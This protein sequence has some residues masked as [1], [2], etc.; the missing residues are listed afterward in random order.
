MTGNWKLSG[1]WKLFLTIAQFAAFIVVD[2]GLLESL[3]WL[4]DAACPSGIAR[5]SRTGKSR[6]LDAARGRQLHPSTAGNLRQWS[7]RPDYFWDAPPEP[8]EDSECK[9]KPGQ[10]PQQFFPLCAR[11]LR[12]IR[13]L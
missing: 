10:K 13:A 3:P 4:G 1:N 9:S 8:G 2:P 12:S 5:F 11:R 7:Y 6:F